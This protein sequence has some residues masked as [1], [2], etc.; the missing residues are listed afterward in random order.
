M[1][2][3]GATALSRVLQAILYD[4]DPVDPWAFGAA[5]LLLL[6]V[7][8]TANLLPARRAARISPVRALRYE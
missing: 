7:A 5:S 3:V 1:G 6:G 4:V 8:F 2:L